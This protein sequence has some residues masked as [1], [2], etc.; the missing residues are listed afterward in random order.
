M[1]RVRLHSFLKH[2][3]R[4]KSALHSTSLSVTC[5]RKF[6]ENLI[7]PFALKP[8]AKETV[9]KHLLRGRNK[10]VPPIPQT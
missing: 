2:Q 9:V 3:P 1:N 10:S 6:V 7:Y 5:Y 4:P 8:S